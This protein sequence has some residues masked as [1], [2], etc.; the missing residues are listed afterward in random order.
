MILIWKE[1]IP[2]DTKMI[3]VFHSLAKNI[4]KYE[5]TVDL[6]KIINLFFICYFSK[7]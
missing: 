2:N 4:A 5:S 7:A 3:P 6:V 1:M